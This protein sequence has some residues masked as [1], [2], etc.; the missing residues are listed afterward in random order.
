MSDSDIVIIDMAVDPQSV[1]QDALS[2]I[3]ITVD[4]R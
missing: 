3:T 2:L 4:G 1:V